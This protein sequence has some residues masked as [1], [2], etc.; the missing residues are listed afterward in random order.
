MK[1]IKLCLTIILLLSF[2]KL[3]YAQVDRTQ[4]PKSGPIP[5]IDLLKPQTFKLKNGLTVLVV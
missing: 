1:K 3:T 5:T 2:V 4:Q